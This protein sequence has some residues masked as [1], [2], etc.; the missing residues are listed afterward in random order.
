MRKASSTRESG[1]LVSKYQ[2][3]GHSLATFHDQKEPS[4]WH[5]AV[6]DGSQLDGE[7]DLSAKL[8]P[9]QLS[10]HAVA[11]AT[12]AFPGFALHPLLIEQVIAASPAFD[13]PLSQ[14][15]QDL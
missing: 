10:L 11:F 13:T 3:L 9:P 8:G 5:G 12:R 1:S 6:P 14:R 7:R 4:P 15:R 2:G